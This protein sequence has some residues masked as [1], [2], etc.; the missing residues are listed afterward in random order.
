MDDTRIVVTGERPEREERSERERSQA[1]SRGARRKATCAPAGTARRAARASISRPCSTHAPDE[2]DRDYFAP[3]ETS[4]V[5]SP[6]SHARRA[7]PSGQKPTL[8]RPYSLTARDTPASLFP[9]PS[10]RGMERREAPGRLAQRP[11]A[12]IDGAR[13]A[14]TALPG[15]PGS[16]ASGARAPIDGGGCASRRSTCG[17]HCRRTARLAPPSRRHSR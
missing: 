11:L 10:R 12:G 7:R 17:A 3:A 6:L 14:P 5:T 8:R 16:T 4:A 15:Y 13:R 2:G 1:R 9:L